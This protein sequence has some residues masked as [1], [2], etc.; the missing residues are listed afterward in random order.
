MADMGLP[1]VGPEKLGWLPSH[2]PE[3]EFVGTGTGYSWTEGTLSVQIQ[4]VGFGADA[5]Y[6]ARVRQAPDYRPTEW[7]WAGSKEEAL[8]AALQ[9]I[10]LEG[11]DAWDLREEAEGIAEG[12]R[13]LRAGDRKGNEQEELA[14]LAAVEKALHELEERRDD[15]PS[16][17]SG[18][19][20]L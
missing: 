9:S 7:V 12:I 13:L 15:A 8:E 5:E 18:R 10:G 14:A 16:R 4:K 20:D 2:R 19:E 3:R 17:R 6:K 11:P 1:R